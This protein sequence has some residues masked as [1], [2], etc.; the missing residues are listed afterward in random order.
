MNMFTFKAD[1]F[2]PAERRALCRG[3]VWAWLAFAPVFGFRA[4]LDAPG[5][6]V[7]EGALFGAFAFF[8]GVLSGLKDDET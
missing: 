7:V 4:A 2:G 6:G 1:L 8:P 3:L 5:A